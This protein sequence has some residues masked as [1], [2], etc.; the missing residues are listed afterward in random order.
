MTIEVTLQE[1]HCPTCRAVVNGVSSK[2]AER[3]PQ[4]GSLGVCVYCGEFLRFGKD[5]TLERLPDADFKALPILHQELLMSNRIAFLSENLAASC[6]FA[7]IT[8]P[9]RH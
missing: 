3:G 7:A 9:R 2:T 4:E 6:G 8:L 1:Q 5:L